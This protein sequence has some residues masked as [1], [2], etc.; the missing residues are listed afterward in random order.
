MSFQVT[1]IALHFHWLSQ[2]L[3]IV[4]TMAYREAMNDKKW[5]YGK[6]KK[7]ASL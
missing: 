1:S 4:H 7:R 5:K 2:D 3:E 6:K